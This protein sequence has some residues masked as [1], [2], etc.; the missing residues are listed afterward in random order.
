[1]L[2]LLLFMVNV[3]TE[4]KHAKASLRQ[5]MEEK[6]KELEEEDSV[7]TWYTDDLLKRSDLAMQQ[8]SKLWDAIRAEEGKNQRWRSFEHPY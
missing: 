2:I 4:E 3:R 6:F 7:R 8:I 5:E 1:M